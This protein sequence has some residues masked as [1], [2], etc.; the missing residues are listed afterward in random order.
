M[1]RRITT[2][3]GIATAILGAAT[4]M[5]VLLSNAGDHA[6]RGD[7]FALLLVLTA[8]SAIV[9]LDG[10]ITSLAVRSTAR[11]PADEA[12][13][14]VIDI[15]QSELIPILRVEIDRAVASA[16]DAG[17]REGIVLGAE[18]IAPATAITPINGRR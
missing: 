11:Q 3:T 14:L 6:M 17:R 9:T 18:G 8:I 5:A 15:A 7:I 2:T 16:R 1:H 13:Q 4:L 10:W 12:R